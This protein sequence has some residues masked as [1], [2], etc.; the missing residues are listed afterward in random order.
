MSHAPLHIPEQT[1]SKT[2]VVV[3]LLNLYSLLISFLFF[4]G[5]F[6]C[7]HMGNKNP[8]APHPTPGYSGPHMQRSNRRC[9]TGLANSAGAHSSGSQSCVLSPGA[10]TSTWR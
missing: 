6:H 5:A 3:I 9:L 7:S 8:A 10:R 1:N 4:G 2:Q